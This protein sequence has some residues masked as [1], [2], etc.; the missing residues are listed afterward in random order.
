MAALFSG[1]RVS[2]GIGKESSRGVGVA[3][4]YWLPKTALT[5]DNKVKR[6]LTAGSYGNISD[7]AMTAY[8]VSKWAEGNIEGEINIDSFGLLLLALCGTESA[9]TD[10]P[11]AGVCTHSYTLQNDNQHD[12]LSI[13]LYDPIG[14]LQFKLA[15]INSLGI[16]ISLGEIVKY[17]ANFISKTS[18]D[19]SSTPSY[20]TDKRFTSRDLIFKVANSISALSAASAISVKHLTL[21]I[22]KNVK[23]DEVLGTLE[24]EDVLNLGIKISG[25]IELNYED[26]TWRD[27]MLNGNTKAMQVKL[28]SSQTIGAST[29]PKLEFVFP[30]VSFS[31]WEPSHSL[32][33]IVGQ[34][35]NFEVLLDISTDPARLWSLCEVVNTKN[36]SY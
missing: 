3:A 26:R 1:R 30:K 15:M 36:E 22:E 6:A 25:T 31:E 4:S 19:S 14:S 11:E 27:Y 29:N 5:F 7:A 34:N 18:V 20:I 28:E 2:V 33:D 16:D 24:P 21:D 23:L 32:D 17:V 13:H 8:V 12:S 35:I 9:S 10:D